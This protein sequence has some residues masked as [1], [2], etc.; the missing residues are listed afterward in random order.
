MAYWIVGSVVTDVWLRLRPTGTAWP[1]VLRRASQ[2]PR[3]LVGMMFAHLGVAAF[4]FGVTMVKAYEIERDV[5]MSVGDTTTLSGYTFAFRGTRDLIGPN[6]SGVAAMVEVSRNGKKL[7]DM[8]PEKRVY[9]VQQNPMTEAAI[10]PGLTRD[11]YVALGEPEEDSDAWVVRI[12]VK[13]FID[14]IW[15]GCL[16][17][18]LG[19]LLAVSDRRYRVSQRADQRLGAQVGQVNV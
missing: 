2:L 17:M 7:F 18:A 6:Y 11:L 8:E 15:G 3:A 4:C 1:I 19:G 9:R 14:W 10:R 13:P 12:Y 5:R 16:L